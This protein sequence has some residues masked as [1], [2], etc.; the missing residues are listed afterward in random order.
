MEITKSDYVQWR[1]TPVTVQ[2]K[3]EMLEVVE[4]VVASLVNYAGDDSKA[5]K[6]KK[7]II[8]GVQWLLDWRPT[9]IE[10]NDA[11]SAGVSH[12]Y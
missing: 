12:S 1:D 5:D 3:K 2:F 8:K 10:E 6:E 9:F 7:G 11:E 4:E